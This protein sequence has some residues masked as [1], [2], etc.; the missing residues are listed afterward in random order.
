MDGDKWASRK[1]CVP[2][3]TGQC[4]PT[5]ERFRLAPNEP[6]KVSKHRQSLGVISPLLQLLK[7]ELLSS[8]LVQ[9]PPSHPA[10]ITK[11]Y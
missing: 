6:D 10:G 4:V 1:K 7:L 8:E 11:K 2:T 9:I 5:G 3:E